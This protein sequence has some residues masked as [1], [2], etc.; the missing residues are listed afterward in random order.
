MAEARV[1][2]RLA[3][4][5]AA[6]VAGYSRL[7]GVDEE[8]T[9][10]SLKLHRRQVIDPKIAEH[11]GRIVKTTGDGALVEFS[12][13]VDAVRCAME[14]QQAMAERNVNIPEDRRTEFRIGINVGDIIIDEADIYGDG[15]NIAA[16]VEGLATPGSVCLSDNAYQQVKGKLT[17]DVSDMGEQQ[18]KNIAQPVR[19]Y[20]VR[21]DGSPASPALTLPDK[22]SIAV[23]PFLNMSGDPEQEYFADGIVEDIITALSRFRSFFVIARNSSFTYKGRNVDVRQ[24]GRELGVRYV[25]EGSVRKGGNKLRITG[26]LIEAETGNH[27]W[28]EKYDGAI[29]DI[30]DLQDK[31]T[32]GVV[33][34]IAPKL[35]Q[36]EIDRA[37]RKPTDS[38]DAYDYYLRALSS[39]QRTTN[40][41]ISD[42]LQLL[43]RAIEIDPEFAEAYA[44]AAACYTRRRSNTWIVDSSKEIA[45]TKRLVRRAVD[46]GKDDAV[47]LYRAGFALARVAGDLDGGA[48]FINRALALNP[49]LAAAWSYSGWLRV[50]LGEPDLAIE[51]VKRAMRLSPLDP[52]IFSMQSAMAAAQFFVGRYDEAS[53]WA[54]MALH[55]QQNYLPAARFFAASTALAGR[56]E[57]ARNAVAR[58][59]QLDP[60]LR[61]SNLNE[62]T[63]VRRP[64]DIARLA[65]AMRKAGLPE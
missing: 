61:I 20:G 36:A 13:A 64:Q 7:M 14:I 21:L 62:H 46:L 60:S 11:R 33:G 19:V 25:L 49:N 50:Y 52:L 32:E 34:A 22:P 29:E 2:R 35:E 44:L 56:L 45:E 3:A 8:G 31:I 48:V 26:Q 53:S 58:A 54:A 23:L 47:T 38:L 65:E 43:Y 37:K 57:E 63:P 51:H 15:V 9:L 41:S 24:I 39:F 12:S 4:I 28:A 59:R 55:E 1:E 10:A 42:A 30:F 27:F 17:L 16:R 5:L 6:D 40:E 18:L